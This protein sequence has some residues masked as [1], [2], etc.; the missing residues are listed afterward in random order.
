MRHHLTLAV[1]LL[2]LVPAATRPQSRPETN[3][4]LMEEVRRI[5]IAFARTMADRDH[6]AFV[7]F[8]AQDA[9]FGGSPRVLRGPA[10]IA[11]G[12]KSFFEGPAAPFS[13]EPEQVEVIESGT[14][15]FSSGPVR[16]P[17]GKR[18][19]TFNSVWRRQ[20]GGEWKVVFDRGCPACD[21]API[22]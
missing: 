1:L 17:S 16:N 15:A 6:P 11:Q 20:A 2:A 22:K 13:W 8:L 21:C 3:A 10:E 14:L 18:T 9:V 4:E 7:K 5:E 19:G 12:W